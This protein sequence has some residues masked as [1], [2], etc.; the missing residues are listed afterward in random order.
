MD[1]GE[2]K[3]GGGC[4][5]SK[6]YVTR[7]REDQEQERQHIWKKAGRQK[8]SRADYRHHSNTK[9]RSENKATAAEEKGER[10]SSKETNPS[11][12]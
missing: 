2:I 9:R 5:V 7:F 3:L 4:G 6:S 1:R 8:H 11:H 10:K 12:D